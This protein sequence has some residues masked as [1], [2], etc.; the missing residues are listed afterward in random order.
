MTINPSLAHELSRHEPENQANP[1]Y[2]ELRSDRAFLILAHFLSLS[3]S[4]RRA[5][6]G[7]VASD[8][9]IRHYVAGLDWRYY[10]AFGR[11][12]GSAVSALA[13]LIGGGPPGWQR[14]E[15]A[16]SAVGQRDEV[17]AELLQIALLAAREQGADDVIIS[18]E[19]F[20]HWVPAL[21]AE[22]GGTLDAD[23]GFAIIPVND[24]VDARSDISGVPNV[25]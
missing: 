24:R 22:L 21:A 18:Y 14:P 17:R 12:N 5:R 23:K 11:L 13:E 6:F 10:R 15:L 1:R 20:E 25:A 16:V 8:H 9:Q 4:E 3:I 7:G 19:A 2:N